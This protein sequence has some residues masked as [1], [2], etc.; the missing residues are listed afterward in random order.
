MQS[1][2]K[3]LGNYIKAVK[4]KNIDLKASKLLGI[5]IDKFFMPSVANVIGTDMSNYKIVRKG[6]FACNRMHVGRDYRIPIALSKEDEPFMVSP[7]YDVFE[8]TDTDILLPE[9]LMMW[10]SRKEFDRNAWFHTDADVRGG[11]PWSALCNLK[12][13]IPSSEKQ[14]EIVREY[15]VIQSRI[16]LN[17]QFISKLEESAYTIYKQWF[18][19]FD[20]PN[21]NGLPYKSNGGKLL[22]NEN[23]NK[24]IPTEWICGSLGEYAQIKS[25]F[26]FKSECWQK[27]GSPVIKIGS[28]KNK[29]IDFDALD[30]VNFDIAKEKLAYSVKSGDIVIA[31]TGFTMGKIGLIPDST[32]PMLVNQRVGFFDLGDN[33]ITKAPFLY[34]TLSSENVQI[35]INSV[36]GDSRQANISGPQIEGIKIALPP[37]A[38]SEKFNN[39]IFPVLKNIMFRHKENRLLEEFKKV[40]QEKISKVE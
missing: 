4:D 37:K 35:E 11:L 1:N 39:I 7:A 21:E 19:D 13:P 30:F 12:I 34:C 22:V 20:F 10:F 6:Q 14:C 8:I 32:E 38:L 27:K 18:L 16:A 40:L 23:L 17:K 29:S 5:N 36:G 31:M 28:I 9:Y 3:R 26:A 33:P 15:D 2:Y 25:G 24:E